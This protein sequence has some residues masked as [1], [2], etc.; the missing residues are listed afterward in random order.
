MDN[1]R[2][3]ALLFGMAQPEEK[4]VTPV[5]LVV[6]LVLVV[7][8]FAFMFSVLKTHVM[9]TDPRM[10][11]IWGLIATS[12]LTGVFWLAL[13]MFRVVFRAHRAAKK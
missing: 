2:V 11:V 10:V 7:L 9:S 8:F 12:C 5:S 3:P 13:Q 1:R 6:D 4:H